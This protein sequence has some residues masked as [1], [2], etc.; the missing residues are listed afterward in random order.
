MFGLLGEPLGEAPAFSG[1]YFQDFAANRPNKPQFDLVSCCAPLL[2]CV[3]L[4]HKL[5]NE[6]HQQRCDEL[7][8][9]E[10]RI[11]EVHNE[12]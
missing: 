2:D 7:R 4:D 5:Q 3:M 6:I 1:H 10:K 8:A 9:I 12:S 11:K